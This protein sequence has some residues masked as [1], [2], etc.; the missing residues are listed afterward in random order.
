MFFLTLVCVNNYGANDI[1]LCLYICTD[2]AFAEKFHL[3]EMIFMYLL[4]PNIR[5]NLQ[6]RISKFIDYLIK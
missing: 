5:F 6:N 3:G 1:C 2:L 4:K